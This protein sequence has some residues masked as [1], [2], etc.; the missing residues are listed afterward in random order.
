M[1][2]KNLAKSRKIEIVKL[3]EYILQLK[4]DFNQQGIELV[5]L[6]TIAG[7]QVELFNKV[8]LLQ[9]K[10]AAH[11][12]K[13]VSEGLPEEGKLVIFA[14]SLVAHS[15]HYHKSEQGD[16]RIKRRW[17]HYR[18]ITLPEQEESAEK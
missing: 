15:T 17:T 6:Q 10:L 16:A 13:R 12:W 1:S 18:Y 9:A 4:D 8:K 11:P 3:N 7:S 2:L 5:E 14:D